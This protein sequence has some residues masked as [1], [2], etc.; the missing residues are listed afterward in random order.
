MPFVNEVGSADTEYLSDG[1]T[2]ALIGALA[3]LPGLSVKSRSSVFRY[4]GMEIDS[5]K[6]GN[7]LGVQA[8]LSGRLIQRGDRL[9]LSLELVD[10][11]NDTVIWSSRYDR[12]MTDVASLQ[13]EIAREVSQQ[14][15]VK[16]SGGKDDPLT[17]RSTENSE[18]YL[19]YLKG[20]YYTSRYTR[21]GLE[22]GLG[23]FNEAV[24]IDPAYANAYAG[25]AYNYITAADWFLPSKEAIQKAK[26][27]AEKAISIDPGHSD[28]Q[29]SLATAAWWYD[30]NVKTAEKGFRRS[31]DLDKNNAHKR[32]IFGW[33][34]VSNGRFEEGLEQNRDALSRD[35]LSAEIS[36]LYGQSLYFAHRYDLAEEQLRKTVKLDPDYWLAHVLLAKTLEATGRKREALKEAKRALELENEVPEIKALVAHLHAVSGDIQEARKILDELVSLAEKRFVPA[37]NLADIYVALGDNQ[38]ALDFLEKAYSDRSFFL[39]MLRTEPHFDGLRSDPR[40]KAIMERTGL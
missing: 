27:A 4:K 11:L 15:K 28:A 1:L 16:L 10:S 8:L 3:R 39:V 19:L 9:D 18:A 12:K 34:L 7:D 31:I 13:D 29:G 17:G 36:A 23:Y 26:A 25:I 24:K 14:L 22:R 37:Y 6:V 35:P 33:F 21:E 2:E 38:R 32:A 20:R 30:Y 40:Y 5:K